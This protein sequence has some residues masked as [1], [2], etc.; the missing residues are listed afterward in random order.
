M[1]RCDVTYSLTPVE[2]PEGTII[3]VGSGSGNLSFTQASTGAINGDTILI[4][5]GSYENI[6][7]EDFLLI[8]GQRVYIKNAGQVFVTGECILDNLEGVTFAGDYINGMTKGFKFLDIPFRA[9][10]LG[11]KFTRC[12][13]KSMLFKDVA[14]LA[15]ATEPNI[16]EM[17]YLGTYQTRS[18]DN[19]F[20]DLEFDNAT[21]ISI[22]GALS[23][24][25]N[26]DKGFQKNIEIASCYFH[27]TDAGSCVY[28]GN[29]EAANVHHNRFDNIN[30]TNQNHN[31][32]T[33]MNGNGDYH[34]NYVS[35]HQGDAIRAWIYSRG[36]TVRQ[37]CRIF[38]N[39]VANSR[40]YSAFEFQGFARYIIAGKTIAADGECFNN[41]CFNLHYEDISD[42][43][44]PGFGNYH[45]V[46]LDTY[47]LFGGTCKAWNNVGVQFPFKAGG[48]NPLWGNALPDNTYDN[49][50]RYYDTLADAGLS[51]DG[52]FTVLNG[53]GT[54]S[55]D[56]RV[57]GY[58]ITDYYDHVRQAPQTIGAVQKL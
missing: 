20:I 38:N 50:N 56:Y 27:N 36:T 9:I 17:A 39:I 55:G 51:S 44:Y 57:D 3:N 34:H 49:T 26:Y 41:T 16:N 30:A 43:R 2:Q 23:G 31:G 52:L 48:T 42:G 58:G 21:G 25:D 13:I 24:D 10:K 18:E 53:S 8:T 15:I 12:T 46:I 28:L 14:D 4:A 45:G 22:G 5:A 47:G 7:I 32:I 40:K 35:N 1:I 19:K 6:V 54:Y 11:T 37:K 33:Q 29:V